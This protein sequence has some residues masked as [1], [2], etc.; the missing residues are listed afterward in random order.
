M[1]RL[2]LLGQFVVGVLGSTPECTRPIVHHW[3][4]DE[5]LGNESFTL[6]GDHP[7][8][9]KNVFFTLSDGGCQ[10]KTGG[11]TRLFCNGYTFSLDCARG[12]AGMNRH[13]IL[14]GLGQSS[15]IWNHYSRMILTEAS[16]TF[17]TADLVFDDDGMKLQ[18]A[19][20][21]DFGHY[22]NLCLH[23]GGRV[24]YGNNRNMNETVDIS[25]FSDRLE[26]SVPHMVYST[27]ISGDKKIYYSAH[28]EIDAIRCGKN[29]IW[30]SD[31]WKDAYLKVTRGENGV[32]V[33][34]TLARHQLAIS[35]DAHGHYVIIRPFSTNSK[36]T[37]LVSQLL[38]ITKLALL[39]FLGTTTSKFGKFISITAILV[40]IEILIFAHS[41]IFKFSGLGQVALLLALQLMG[42]HKFGAQPQAI[43]LALVLIQSTLVEL[44]FFELSVL[45]QLAHGTIVITTFLRL[46]MR[47]ERQ[48]AVIFAGIILIS[49]FLAIDV[50]SDDVTEITCLYGLA[51][52]GVLYLFF[53]EICVALSLQWLRRERK[54][55]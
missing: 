35:Y 50:L 44:S 36:F 25:L 19:S 18:C 33:L 23:S 21:G 34:G 55:D 31:I 24:V 30:T 1:L 8:R 15:V 5:S 10:T 38:L 12:P 7:A 49:V 45:A 14:L 43:I 17:G 13:D 51:S 41:V 26:T 40:G 53:T 46:V 20:Q 16:I 47:G 9:E 4:D 11:K 37:K 27:V 54:Q 6:F 22:G 2:F 42:G 48:V 39:C 32:L 52:P 28:G 3:L 29:C